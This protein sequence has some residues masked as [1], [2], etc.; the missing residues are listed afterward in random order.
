[1][2]KFENI[3]RK[4]QLQWGLIICKEADPKHKRG[5]IM[6]KEADPKHKQV[7]SW[8]PTSEKKTR[9]TKDKLN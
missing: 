8:N 2:G 4:K 9:S 1:M 6:C 5:L 7:L 3:M